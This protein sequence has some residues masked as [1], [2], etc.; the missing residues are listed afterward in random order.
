MT[1]TPQLRHVGIAALTGLA[2]MAGCSPNDRPEAGSRT[3]STPASPEPVPTATPTPLANL[4]GPDPN[5]PVV[6]AF[7]DSLTAGHMVASSMSYPAQLASLLETRGYGRYQV[8]NDGESGLTTSGGLARLDRAL[9]L[10][11]EIVILTL[12]GNDG[13]RGTPIT[14]ARRNLEVLVSA[15]RDSGARVVLGGITLPRNYGPDYIGE[16]ERMYVDLAEE[17]DVAFMPFFL[18]GLV[19]LDNPTENIGRYM[20]SDGIHPTAE[21]YTIVADHVFRVIEPYLEK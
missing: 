17:F 11:P 2:L 5:R 13:L 19:D 9:E 18:E 4:A 15:F 20:Q 7:G 1:I 6:L 8:I 3:S 21:G 12:G 14:E 10:E 16:F